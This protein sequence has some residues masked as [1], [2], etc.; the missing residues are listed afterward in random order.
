M[1]AAIFSST[2]DSLGG[3]ERYVSV[4]ANLLIKNGYQV[5]IWWPDDLR[6]KIRDR[7]G[8]DLKSAKFIDYSPLK[9]I[10]F[11]RL[12]KTREYDLIFWVSD[13]SLPLSLAKK[14]IIHFQIPFHGPN[15]GSLANKLKARLYTS[16]CNS[17]FTKSFIDKTYSINSQV[18]YPPVDT[19]IIHSGD[20]KNIILVLARFSQILHAKRQDL[21]IQAFSRLQFSGWR[22]VLAGGST[23]SDYL[24]HL[25][26]LAKDLPVDI[27]PNPSLTQVRQLLSQAKIFWSATG[28]D[29]N[30]KLFP[31]KAEHFGITPVEAMAAG[32]V[33]V[34]TNIGGHT[35]TIVHGQSG[36]LWST[37]EDLIKFTQR[38]MQDEKLWN[39]LSQ[40]ATVRSQ[41]FSASVF[42]SKFLKLI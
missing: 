41:Q 27:I 2:W 42:E 34:V 31:E 25:Q 24:I 29:I 15:C 19:D 11:S 7:F 1:K 23:D 6:Q 36:F 17:F 18:I 10:F 3:G 12:K 40:A 35:E 4:F 13:G 37:L 14:T 22:L 8:V 21:L 39:T 9:D 5:E 20:K 28:Y 26:K 38:L 30:P 32:C 16:V 33:P